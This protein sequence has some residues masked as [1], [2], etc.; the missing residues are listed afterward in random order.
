MPLAAFSEEVRRQSIRFDSP[1]PIS[2]TPWLCLLRCSCRRIRVCTVW[3]VAQL[4]GDAAVPAM[5]VQA[6]KVRAE[7][8]EALEKQRQEREAE[9]CHST[10]TRHRTLAQTHAIARAITD[11]YHGTSEMQ[12]CTQWHGTTRHG[13]RCGPLTATNERTIVSDPQ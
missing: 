3:S 12:R 7:R 9:A 2:P 6:S 5:V 4:H 13:T 10:L 11:T 1:A 8:Q